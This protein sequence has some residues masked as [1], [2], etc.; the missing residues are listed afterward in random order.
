M[1]AEGRPKRMEISRGTA[2]MVGLAQVAVTLAVV[3]C[4]PAVHVQIYTCHP[5]V[6]NGT[7]SLAEPAPLHGTSLM[8]GLPV[9]ASCNVMSLAYFTL[10]LGR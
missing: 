1:D 2:Y 6:L 10:L 9:R 3:L 7:T 5:V 8:M 4:F